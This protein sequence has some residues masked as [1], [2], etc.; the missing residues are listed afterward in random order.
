L[1]LRYPGTALLNTEYKQTGEGREERGCHPSVLLCW[2]TVIWSG[3]PLIPWGGGPHETSFPRILEYKSEWAVTYW[4]RK[5]RRAGVYGRAL[6]RYLGYRGQEEDTAGLL[7]FLQGQEATDI[8]TA[9]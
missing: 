7:A 4:Y 5:N 1:G 8:G 3:A 2:L 9:S 6:A